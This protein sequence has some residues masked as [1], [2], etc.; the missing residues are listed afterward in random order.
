[1]RLGLG[2]LMSPATLRRFDRFDDV[3]T[4]SRN[5]SDLEL[6]GVAKGWHDVD[7][8]FNGTAANWIAIVREDE[9]LLVARPGEQRPLSDIDLVE[10]VPTTADGRELRLR[11]RDGSVWCAAYVPLAP[12]HGESEPTA[13]AGP[14]DFDF[15]QYLRALV[16]DEDRQLRLFRRAR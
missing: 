1:M 6:G 8:I 14:E 11:F 5:T 16:L 7:G 15:G 12:L 13:F 3:R 2:L 10:V 9:E 4:W